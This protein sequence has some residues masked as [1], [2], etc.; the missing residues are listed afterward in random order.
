MA[1]ATM[2]LACIGSAMGSKQNPSTNYHGQASYEIET[3]VDV[4]YSGEETELYLKFEKFPEE[5]RRRKLYSA[6]VSDYYTASWGSYQSAFDFSVYVLSCDDFDE[7]TVTYGSKPQWRAR[8]GAT[9]IHWQKYAQPTLTPASPCPFPNDSSSSND[10]IANR[11]LQNSCVIL[12]D[13]GKV[14]YDDRLWLNT[15]FASNKPL[16]TVEYDD[17]TDVT[18]KISGTY[19]TSGKLNRFIDNT[20]MWSIA[21][22]EEAY[23]LKDPVQ[24]SAVFQWR[25]STSGTWNSIQVEGDEKKLKIPAGT[26][27]GKTTQW[28]VSFTDDMGVVRTSDT[29][30]LDTSAG[31]LKAAPASPIAGAFADPIEDSLFMWTNS[32]TSGNV[33]QSKADL[34]YSEDGEAWETLGSVTGGALSYTVPANTFQTGTYYWRV[35]AYNADGEAGPWSDPAEFSTVDAPMSA[36][37]VRP[38]SEIC[39]YNSPITF[40][41]AHSSDTGTTPTK[42]EVQWSRDSAAWEE[43][44]TT[45]ENVHSY[46]AP[47]DTF[48]A[49]TV[50]WRVRNY[51]HNGVAGQWSDVVSFIS[52]GAPYPPSVSVDAVPFATIVWQ[53]SGQEAWRVTVDG[54][55]F[56]PFFG[57][58]KSFTVEEPLE[59][60]R[61]TAKVEIQGAYGLWSEAAA[62]VFDIQNQ[63]GEPIDLNG[64]FRSDAALSWTTGADQ[65]DFRVYR[66]GVLIGK[67]AER[68]YI[69]RFVLGAHS[70]QVMNR[71]A[72]GFYSISNSVEGELAA[73]VPQIAGFPR[74]DWIAL[75]LSDSEHREEA[76]TFSRTVSLRHVVGA[77]FPVLETSPFCDETVSYDAAFTDQRS[78]AAFEQL[79]G[80]AVIL[81]TKTGVTIG[82]MS[83]VQRIVNDFYLSYRFTIQRIHWEDFMDDS[84]N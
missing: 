66:D 27:T 34:Q 43:L 69:D 33:T 12:E 42:S 25:A 17:S 24:E 10:W 52:Y 26:F 19:Y 9:S 23:C 76:T 70:W 7:N 78:A 15:R 51:N 45:G 63:P 38:I 8:L 28:R 20:F 58:A 35:R 5:L 79:R 39:E 55:T 75:E 54:K 50:Y 2:T 29:Y 30:T 6:V 41:W 3:Y 22:A 36:A 46:T 40:Q 67:T 21:K 13:N 65:A 80:Q 64:I 18:Y 71:L 62:V 72:G 56:G 61:H 48:P 1:R 73:D 32:S 47:A 11:I 59:D 84:G 83:Q 68:E 77:V 49:G 57:T 31:E 44:I 16:L 74:G 14:H 4:R 37:A 82:C 53:S 60:G 81:K